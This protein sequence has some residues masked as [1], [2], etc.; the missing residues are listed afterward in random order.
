LGLPTVN[1]TK[2]VPKQKIQVHQTNRKGWE[3]Q[4]NP[5]TGRQTY[6]DAKI[7]MALDN[8]NGHPVFTHK[9]F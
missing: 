4:I 8:V 7:G 2:P 3:K 5:N 6:L 1:T 9:R